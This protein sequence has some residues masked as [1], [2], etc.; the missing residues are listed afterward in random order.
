MCLQ[1][2][3]ANL[4]ETEKRCQEMSQN[5]LVEARTTLTGEAKRMIQTNV[6]LSEELRFQLQ[7]TA[8]LQA[9]N[10]QLE[11]EVASLKRDVALLHDQDTHRA[12]LAHSRTKEVSYK[13]CSF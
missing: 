3:S 12:Q 11:S 10:V 2:G 8:D 9:L 13:L 4:Q 1:I 6:Q 7:T 5:A